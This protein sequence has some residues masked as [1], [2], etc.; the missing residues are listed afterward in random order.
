M[1]WTAILSGHDV[2]IADYIARS[3]D[4]A[5]F[6]GPHVPYSNGLISGACNDLVPAKDL[7]LSFLFSWIQHLLVKLHTVDTILMS[8][9]I[10]S[11]RISS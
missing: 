2:W 6:V 9:Q 8:I 11:L 3:N 7:V 4:Q 1:S 10:D 5:A